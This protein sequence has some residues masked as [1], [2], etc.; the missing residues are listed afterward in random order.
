MALLSFA[1]PGGSPH[2]NPKQCKA[3]QSHAKR[4]SPGNV[5]RALTHLAILI[6]PKSRG[7]NMLAIADACRD[8]RLDAAVKVVIAPTDGTTPGGMTPVSSSTSGN[9]VQEPQ[10]DNRA[11]AAAQARDLNLAIV[12]PGDDY[13]PRLLEHLQDIDYI[14]LAGYMRLL[15][16]EVLKAFPNR[17]LNVHPALLPE[18]GGKGMYGR[19]VH[20]AVLE[21]G[22]SESGCTVHLVNEAY[23]EGRILL[24]RRCVV[25]PGDTVES[26]AARVLALE[27]EAYVE[28]LRNVISG[29]NA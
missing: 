6:G 21:A 15:P 4:P 5:Q 12:A 14:C 17:I 9:V 19:R 29:A 10:S 11:V 24:Q 25:L 27:H 1:W 16:S 18:F 22:C 2:S 7:S 23:D 3:M 20:E 26:L 28:A 13:G 8:G